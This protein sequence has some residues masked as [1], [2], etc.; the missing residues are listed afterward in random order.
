M[1]TTRA[2]RIA[3]G[4]L[5][6][7]LQLGVFV[8]VLCVLT[9]SPLR[10]L[11]YFSPAAVRAG[12]WW[13]IVTHP[14]VHV[15]WYHL[16][17][18]GVAFCMLYH[19]LREPSPVCR[20]GF[21]VASA[22]G[23]LAAAWMF[24]PQVEQL[25]LCGL[26]GVAH[27]LMAITALEMIRDDER[28]GWVCLIAVA[29]KSLW[30]A[31]TGRV[32]F[33]WLHFGRLG[34]PIAVSHLGGVVGGL[35]MWLGLLVLPNPIGS[36]HGI[37]SLAAHATSRLRRHLTISAPCVVCLSLSMAGC[38]TTYTLIGGVNPNA[39]DFC[40]ER[41]IPRVYSGTAHDVQIIQNG[42]EEWGIA[43]FALLDLPMSV[44]A[45]TV[46]LPYTLVMQAKH[47]SLCSGNTE[48]DE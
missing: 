10:D 7:R 17:L 18:D 14:F 25:G 24:A 47:G 46:V 28:L 34:T 44:V 6:T 12:Q 30:E 29:G 13:R 3:G 15:S 48:A 42:S 39:L 41:T 2:N 11:F 23:S 38:S 36:V 43:V 33:E 37:V 16:L 1:T 40:G 20:A 5:A 27:G 26:S 21:V 31:T 4:G 22:A 45:D 8:L 32:L 19:S 9:F 35:V